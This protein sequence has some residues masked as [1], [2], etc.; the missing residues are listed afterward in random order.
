M[1]MAL[2]TRAGV[3]YNF[4]RSPYK[5]TVQYGDGD[6]IV[7]TFSSNLY[8]EKFLER[9]D[10]NRKRIHLSLTKRFNFKIYHN[11]LSD[12]QL[13][14]SIEKRGFM[15]EDAKGVYK[16]PNAITLDG[17]MLMTEK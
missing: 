13:Y 15:I 1:G 5:T 12:L 16:C 10:E 17:L 8:K 3:S 14:M 11:K 7:Y 4:E 9:L 6:S 2:L